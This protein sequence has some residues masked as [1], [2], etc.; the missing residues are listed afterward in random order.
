MLNLKNIREVKDGIIY[1]E[2]EIIDKI[3]EFLKT[4]KFNISI[5]NWSNSVVQKL[6]D[7]GDFYSGELFNYYKQIIENYIIECKN[8]INEEDNV[9]LIDRFLFHTNNIYFLIYQMNKLFHYLERYYLKKNKTL[10][11]VA[12]KLYKSIVFE[13]FKNNIV[14]E[15]DKYHIEQKNVDEESNSKIQSIK[16]I[17]ED[18]KLLNPKLIKENNEIKFVE[19]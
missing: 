8:N 13:T 15:L 16:K 4:G 12:I 10:S 14:E 2:I 6:A 7:F 5:Y 1:L 19:E 18:I 17:F 9:N 3:F 11:K